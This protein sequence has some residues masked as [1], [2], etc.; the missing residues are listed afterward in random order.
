MLR[1][2]LQHPETIGRDV[3]TRPFDHGRGEQG[4]KARMNHTI[5]NGGGGQYRQK[6]ATVKDSLPY[7]KRMPLGA[8]APFVGTKGFAAGL[9]P[10]LSGAR[11][12]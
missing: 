12:A 1:A 5:P 9:K 11:W 2:D 3:R 4:S 7:L 6:Q 10:P 8:T